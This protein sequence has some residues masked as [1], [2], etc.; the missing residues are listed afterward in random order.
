MPTE[1][2][3]TSPE[4]PSSMVPWDATGQQYFSH[5]VPQLVSYKVMLQVI[6]FVVLLGVYI[7]FDDTHKS[8]KKKNCEKVCC[9]AQLPGN[10]AQILKNM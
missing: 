6:T 2:A 3:P 5:I 10:T 7:N 8:K 1:K 9:D 4:S